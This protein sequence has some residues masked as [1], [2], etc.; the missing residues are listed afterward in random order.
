MSFP[1]HVPDEPTPLDADANLLVNPENRPSLTVQR[2]RGAGLEPACLLQARELLEILPHPAAL[3]TR[4]RKKGIFNAEAR[5][6]FGICEHEATHGGSWLERIHPQDRCDYRNALER[7]SRGAGRVRIDYRFC[8][9]GRADPIHITELMSLYHPGADNALQIWSIYSQG[10]PNFTATETGDG[11]RLQELLRGLNHDVSNHLQAI[12]G[13]FALLKITGRIS[14]QTSNAVNHGV[15]NIKKLL[16]EM[17]EYLSPSP[18]ELNMENPA[19][20]FAEVLRKAKRNSR[21]ITFGY[22]L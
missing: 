14:E 6:L 2:P 4:G 1:Q 12:K 21:T 18:L 19:V 3:W 13:E 17:G 15:A 11:K 5:G 7:V 16:L 10:A 22:P 9:A 20:V 8:P